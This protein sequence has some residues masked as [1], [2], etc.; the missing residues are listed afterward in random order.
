MGEVA[1]V[2]DWT[3]Q[4]LSGPGT[5][6]SKSGHEHAPGG[7]RTWARRELWLSALAAVIRSLSSGFIM[8]CSRSSTPAETE[9]I[10]IETQGRSDRTLLT[11]AE[12]PRADPGASDRSL[13]VL[14]ELVWRRKLLLLRL[15]EWG[16]S[17]HD[18]E[19][20]NLHAESEMSLRPRVAKSGRLTPRDQTSDV[21]SSCLTPRARAADRYLVGE[22]ARVRKI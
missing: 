10:S 19:Q 16:P 5:G 8:R 1:S 21:R 22:R 4:G 7:R 14:V 6:A 18:L 15:L 13:V 11:D 17:H 2:V 3:T 20:G 12:I 9:P